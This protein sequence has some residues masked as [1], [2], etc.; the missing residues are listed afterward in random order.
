MWR[1]SMTGLVAAVSAGALTILALPDIRWV[2]LSSKK[3][4]LPVPGEST[5]QTGILVTRVDPRGDTDFIMSF[6]KVAPALVWMRH[7][8]KA[9]KRYV[10]EQEF[11]T[12]EAGGAAYDID[13]DGDLDIVFGNDA[14]GDQLWWWENPYPNYDPATP[15]KRHVIKSG[16]AR[17]HHDQ[18]FADFKGTGHPQLLFWNQKAKTLFMAEIPRDP[19][20]AGPWPLEVIFSGQ[21]GEGGA[22]AAAYAEGIDAIDIDGDGRI[23]LLAGN[24]WFKNLG[25]GKYQTTQIGTIG[26]RIRAGQFKPGPH[27]QVVIAPGTA[28]VRCASTNARAIRRRSESWVGR[29]L[30][31]RDMV[32]GHT[33]DVGDIN[34]DGHLDIFAPKW[35][36][37]P[38]ARTNT[39]TPPPRRGFCTAT[40]RVTSPVPCSRP[41]TDG[42]KASWAISTGMAT[43]ISSTSRTPGARRASI[44][45]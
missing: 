35:P 18:I 33:L 16:G 20:N 38:M 19:R 13:G 24:S 34:G 5:Q 10:I 29:D 43:W 44:C 22:G 23:D 9:W 17:Q 8:D 40:A 27:P 25:N 36:S 2:Q 32:H 3:H 26:G 45:G 28:A 6:R 14:Q 15:W 30:L 7:E 21:A 41:A 31:D 37:G 1:R 39:T 42:T 12:V 4:E 11:L